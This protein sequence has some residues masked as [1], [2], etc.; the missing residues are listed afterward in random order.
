MPNARKK[1][2]AKMEDFKVNKFEIVNEN[3]YWH[4]R[5][6]GKIEKETQG[7]KEEACARQLYWYFVQIQK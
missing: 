3:C 4:K 6:C 5:V 7:G 2:A 1:K